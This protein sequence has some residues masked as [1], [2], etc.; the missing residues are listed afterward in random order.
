[1]AQFLSA[2]A[3]LSNHDSVVLIRQA[4]LNSSVNDETGEFDAAVHELDSAS[5][6]L[7]QLVAAPPTIA[8]PLD[9][10]GQAIRIVNPPE[11]LISDEP[12]T[13]VIGKPNVGWP[14]SGMYKWTISSAAT[15][16]H[17]VSGVDLKRIRY[18]FEQAGTYHVAVDV[19]GKNAETR[20]VAILRA[21]SKTFIERFRLIR[22][23]MIAVTFAIAAGTAYV[24]TQDAPSFG[25]FG[26]YLK[27]F[28]NALGIAGG[29]SSVATILSA[30]RGK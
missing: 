4:I 5:T 18:R 3:D 7:D 26:D 22:A 28:T 16:I 10:S 21:P 1:L 17:Q 29:T 12:V 15:A 6:R 2:H 23:A 14:A 27:L 25:T 19:D 30:L 11:Q 13:F 9:T 8:V 20:D 24:T